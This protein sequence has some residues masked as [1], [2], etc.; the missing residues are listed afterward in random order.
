MSRA[1][2]LSQAYGYCHMA[3]WVWITSSDYVESEG[4]VLTPMAQHMID[5][6]K[7]EALCFKLL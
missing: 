4:D 2:W 6:P 3:Y 7:G 1:S 5:N